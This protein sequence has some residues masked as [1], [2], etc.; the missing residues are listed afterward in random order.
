M[1][2]QDIEFIRQAIEEAR[3]CK[4]EDDRVHPRVGAVV[5]KDG[6]V[7]AAAYRGELAPGDHA[8]F[9][10]LESK[11][12]DEIITGATV[13]TTLEPCT[14]RNH[15]KVPCA[16]RL[17]ERKVARVVIGM[18]DP[19]P[20]I[21]GNGIDA[22]RDANIEVKLFPHVFMSE[23]EELNRHFKRA[24]SKKASGE[25]VS[26]D[27]STSDNVEYKSNAELKE[28]AS[29]R[30][31]EAE[32]KLKALLLE[33]SRLLDDDVDREEFER[34]QE[35]WEAYCNEQAEIAAS[36][37]E[38]GTGW[39]LVYMGEKQALIVARIAEIQSRINFIKSK[40]RSAS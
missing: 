10:A 8:E 16:E 26:Q 14:T 12:A 32:L 25:H 28:D 37:W 19:N 7:L 4:P 18:L 6:K 3:K 27:S 40:F 38:G 15:P 29:L 1:S 34:S 21:K 2:E 36:G 9:T 5:V 23:V 30:I 13:Y 24:H 35:R 17:N 22:L 33:L 39:G 31:E 11:L 20:K